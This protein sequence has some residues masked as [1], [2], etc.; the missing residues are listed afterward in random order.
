M[1][2]KKTIFFIFF[3]VNLFA[4]NFY[5]EIDINGYSEIIYQNDKLLVPTFSNG[6]KI[7]DESIYFHYYEKIPINSSDFEV[8]LENLK[9]EN[10]K[11]FNT[12]IKIPEN[13]EHEFIVLSEKKKNYIGVKIYPYIKKG[14]ETLILK[15]F[16]INAKPKQLK[17]K[18]KKTNFSSNSK[19]NE[20]QWFKI[21]V[22]E[23]GIYSLDYN[24]LLILIFIS[25]SFLMSLR[26]S[27]NEY[28]GMNIKLK[29]KSDTFSQKSLS[30]VFTIVFIG[31]VGALVIFLYLFQSI[32]FSWLSNH[33]SSTDFI[34]KYTSYIL[35]WSLSL[36][37]NY[38]I[39]LFVFKFMHDAFVSW[40]VA[41][42]GA[43]VTSFLLFIGQLLIKF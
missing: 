33:L 28:F 9:F 21:A 13:L 4:Q 10:L 23:N 6:V 41:S 26:R 12:S 32:C 14:S 2:L 19:L 24:F 40:K 18:S 43:L 30:R 1:S 17:S 27:I 15:S 8:T 38:L 20:G 3:T 39:F 42:M 22:E 34:Q 36:L 37:T 7:N 5:R 11:S 25:S 31:V 35:D 29:R 16:T